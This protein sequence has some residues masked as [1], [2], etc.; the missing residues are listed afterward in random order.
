MSARESFWK[1]QERKQICHRDTEARRSTE[2]K[3]I[4]RDEQDIQDLRQ[5]LFDPKIKGFCGFILF[6]LSL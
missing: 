4:N 2:K 6:I 1:A 3:Q 5:I